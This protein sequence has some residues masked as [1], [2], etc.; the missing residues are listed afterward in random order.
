MN[1]QVLL[2]VIEGAFRLAQANQLS[3][4]KLAI[5]REKGSLTAE[6]IQE[7]Q[8]EATEAVNKIGG[9]DDAG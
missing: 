9:G 3:F 5:E 1:A 8:I 2:A 7:L 6:R 4:S